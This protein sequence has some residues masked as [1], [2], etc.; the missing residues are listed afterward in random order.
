MLDVDLNPDSD[1]V[2]TAWTQTL[3]IHLMI[4]VTLMLIRGR[5]HINY[6]V[7]VL[8]VS[9]GYYGLKGGV[10]T[11]LHGGE[12]RVY[13]P[14]GSVIEENN[15]LALALVTLFPL[16]YYLTVVSKQTWIRWGL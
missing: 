3:K 15:A 9:I 10:F 14:P 5:E 12:N 1:A 16:M 6:L 11:L 4:L 13:G 8:V 7:W 2:I